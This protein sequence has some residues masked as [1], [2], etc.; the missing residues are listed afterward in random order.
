M[1]PSPAGFIAWLGLSHARVLTSWG[2]TK[3]A[4]SD[5]VNWEKNQHKTAAGICAFDISHS[6]WE[7][8]TLPDISVLWWFCFNPSLCIYSL[9]EIS[10]VYL[11]CQ[12]LAA[13]G[14]ESITES[15]RDHIKVVKSWQGLTVLRFAQL[16]LNQNIDRKQCCVDNRDQCKPAFVCEV[17]HKLIK[18]SSEVGNCFPACSVRRVISDP[19]VPQE[20]C[21]QGL[22]AKPCLM[23]SGRMKCTKSLHMTSKS[24]FTFQAFISSR[25]IKMSHFDFHGYIN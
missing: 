2:S 15:T 20:I 18:K 14:A 19:A 6:C 7:A 4:D 13:S 23:Y 8:E 10:P 21:S 3:G 12:V 1:C 16:N 5:V 9:L 17:D 25:L 11:F 22:W 24:F